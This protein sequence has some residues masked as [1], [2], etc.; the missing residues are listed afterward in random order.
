MTLACAVLTLSD[1]VVSGSRKDSSGDQVQVMIE[2]SGLQVV[3]RDVLP[4]NR[5]D[6]AALLRQLCSRSDI[7]CVL[8]TGGTGIGPRDVTPEATQDVVERTLPGMAEAMRSETLKKTP[9]AMISRQVVGVRQGTLIVNLPGSPKG[10]SECLEVILPVLNHV[11][12]LIAGHTRHEED[13][14]SEPPQDNS[15]GV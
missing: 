7:Q 2:S 9:F 3:Y 6:I 10:V 1:S 5:E 13:M 14:S 11:V 15:A 12:N 4:D 8:T